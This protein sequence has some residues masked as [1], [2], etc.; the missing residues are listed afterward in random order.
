MGLGHESGS[1]RSVLGLRTPGDRE[2]AGRAA[3]ITPIGHRDRPSRIKR[4]VQ[5]SGPWT[6]NSP[7]VRSRPT[8][9]LR[10]CDPPARLCERRDYARRMARTSSR[11]S[12]VLPRLSVTTDRVTAIR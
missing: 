8:A 5:R 12:T 7:G 6:G 9:R 1:G 4:M 11:Y 3:M 2:Q 10:T